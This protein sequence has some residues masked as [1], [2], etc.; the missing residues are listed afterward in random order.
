M[1]VGQLHDVL[2]RYDEDDRPV[3]I[4]DRDAE[5]K[6]IYRTLLSYDRH[7]R[8]HR[9][10]VRHGER[11]GD[12]FHTT[13]SSAQPPT[14]DEIEAFKTRLT[15]FLRDRVFLSM[16]YTYD[17][18]GRVAH[19]VKRMGG[20][21]EETQSFTYDGHD[22]VLEGHLESI[23]RDGNFDDEGTL[24]AS[25]E[26]AS[27]SWGRYEYRYDERGNWIEKVALRR[28][29]PD[30]A[31]HRSSIERRTI[32]YCDSPDQTSNSASDQA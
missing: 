20:L 6:T 13:D 21:S 16:E 32:T 15:A 31:F 19:L 14:A 9:E 7:G 24:V 29:S 18:G 5:G 23:D 4:V 11:L 8:L 17:E 25:T 26:T 22:N 28:E 10:E 30:G 2:T 27:E 12:S 3:E 1:K